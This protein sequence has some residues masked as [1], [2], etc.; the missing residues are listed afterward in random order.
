[1]HGSSVRPPV[2]RAYALCS[3]TF[4]LIRVGRL[5]KPVRLIARFRWHGARWRI[6]PS[7][8]PI[9]DRERA[10]LLIWR[11]VFGRINAVDLRRENVPD[12]LRVAWLRECFRAWVRQN[13]SGDF[14]ALVAHAYV[15]P[16]VTRRLV[17]QILFYWFAR[18][19][20]IGLDD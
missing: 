6:M 9:N 18:R 15:S 3:A 17:Q 16:R 20:F 5:L 8:T 14:L 12:G 11:L 4:T 10:A 2:C 7:P 19:R 1:M 13:R